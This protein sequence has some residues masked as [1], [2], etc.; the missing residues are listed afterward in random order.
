MPMIQ[1]HL[2]NNTLYFISRSKSRRG[3]TSVSY[4]EV[5][6]DDKTGSDDLVEVEW[7]ET[8]A[9]AATDTSETIEKVLAQRIGKKG[10]KHFTVYMYQ[11]LIKMST[12]VNSV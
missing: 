4:K 12:Q 11:K 5:S 8:E 2:V 10:G 1:T 6:D 3:A 7:N 9:T